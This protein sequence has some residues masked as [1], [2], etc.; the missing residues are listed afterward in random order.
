MPTDEAM[1]FK[2]EDATIIFRNFSGAEGK[3][4]KPGDRNFAVILD[5][6]TAERMIQDGWN[7]KFL[8]AREEDEA[9]T[10]YVQVTVS[11][12][13][14]PPKVVMI[15]STSRAHLNAESVG[16]LDWADIKTVDLIANAYHW[17]VNGKTGVKAY[18]KTMFVTI[19]EDELERKYAI[20][21]MED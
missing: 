14:Y 4:N 10:P 8:A 16:T 20:N 15:T 18:L 21:D 1:T 11:F 13:H 2:V 5:H 3:F 17:E 12:D 9:D 7:V 19:N 6:E